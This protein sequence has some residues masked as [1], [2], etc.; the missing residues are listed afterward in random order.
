MTGTRKAKQP[1]SRTAK[2]PKSQTA[3][4]AEKPN[5]VRVPAKQP[6]P[7]KFWLFGCLVVRRCLPEKPNSRKAEKPNIV[8]VVI[9]CFEAPSSLAG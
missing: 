6:E 5:I 2:Q 1:N 8:H 7:A 9:V 3:E 4:K